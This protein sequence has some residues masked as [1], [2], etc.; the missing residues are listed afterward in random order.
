[1]VGQAGTISSSPAQT[2]TAPREPGG[3]DSS[4]SGLLTA[5]YGLARATFKCGNY[6]LIKWCFASLLL[7]FMVVNSMF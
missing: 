7:D 4:C 2:A 6:K 1:M 3:F 5:V